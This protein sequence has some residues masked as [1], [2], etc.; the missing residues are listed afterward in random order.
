VCTVRS[1]NDR[2]VD[3]DI[4]R[5][6]KDFKNIWWEKRIKPNKYWRENN[7]MGLQKK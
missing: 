5:E 6:S 2:K 4:K 1:K 3:L 7:R